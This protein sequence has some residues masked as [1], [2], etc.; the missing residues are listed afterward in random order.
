MSLWP[1]SPSTQGT[2]H[3]LVLSSNPGWKK[4]GLP[5]FQDQAHVAQHF[6][7]LMATTL[8][9][10]LSRL[11]HWC[12]LP[13]IS[14]PLSSSKLLRGSLSIVVKNISLFWL[15]KTVI[16]TSLRDLFKGAYAR[17]EGEKMRRDSN[18][19][20]P[21]NFQSASTAAVGLI[22]S[23]VI[24]VCGGKPSDVSILKRFSTRPK[25]KFYR[26]IFFLPKTKKVF[27]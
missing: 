2:T 22:R 21:C 4:C 27:R 19:R 16:F 6:F 8:S 7:H 24:Q 13:F 25:K 3:L 1:F 20:L 12:G 17:I 15:G 11:T 18:P 14:W 23:W 5:Q 26:V 9:P 10:L